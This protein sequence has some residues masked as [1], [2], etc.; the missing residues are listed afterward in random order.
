MGRRRPRGGMPAVFDGVSQR[1]DRDGVE[2]FGPA[3]ERLVAL[4]G[5][6]PGE[7][8]LD[9]GCGRGAVLFPA[10]RAAG[11]TG[12]A[13]GVDLA[14]GMVE[15]TRHEAALRGLVQV[16]TQVRDGQDPPFPAGSFD[17]VTGGMS[18]HM[19]GD[20]PAAYRAYHRLLAP[21]GRLGLSAPATVTE[22]E[23]EVFG[24]ASVARM[25]ADHDTGSGVYPYTPAF[26]G[27]ERVRAELTA[28]GFHDVR[29]HRETGLLT[30]ADPAALLRWTW[31]HGMRLLWE[32]V[33]PR[34]RPGYER[35]ITSEARRRSTSPERT[36]LRVP[37]LYVIARRD[38]L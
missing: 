18:I 12:R 28:A 4:T 31:G 1:Y 27:P 24:L 2:F 36:V 13:V 11:P 35:L 10:A 29:V 34:L 23:P 9:I 8:V 19:L 22:P 21:G 38:P 3:G 16:T 17:A 37:L 33:P 25:A 26:G 15:A 7:W 30:A 6:G 14:P 32:R 5:I 20:L